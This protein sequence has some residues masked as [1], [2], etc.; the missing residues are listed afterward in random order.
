MAFKCFLCEKKGIDKVF[1]D[2]NALK[3]HFTNVHCKDGRCPVCGIETKKIGVHLYL[4]ANKDIEHAIAYGLY[5]RLNKN[6]LKDRCIK[7]A[8]LFSIV[9]ETYKEPVE[10]CNT[11]ETQQ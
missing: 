11:C 5:K 3:Y 2:F 10:V 8:Y 4:Y 1:K 7:L 6:K 9:S